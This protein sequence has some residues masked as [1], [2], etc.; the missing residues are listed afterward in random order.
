M[1][2]V[3]ITQEC[4]GEAAT[5]ADVI[6]MIA[7]LRAEGWDARAGVGRGEIDEEYSPYDSEIFD[8]DFTACLNR[9]AS[10]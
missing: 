1:N 4:M 7:M 9:I 5:E 2:I 3:Y 10:A 6:T 8:R